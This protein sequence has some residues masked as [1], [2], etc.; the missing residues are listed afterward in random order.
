MKLFSREAKVTSRRATAGVDGETEETERDGR[1]D[2][3]ASSTTERRT[4]FNATVGVY[5]AVC[6]SEPEAAFCTLLTHLTNDM[7][8]GQL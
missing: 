1:Q 4:L 3:R 5:P 2:Q 6:V 8:Y 7:G